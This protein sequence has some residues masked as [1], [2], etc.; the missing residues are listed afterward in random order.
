MLFNI[1]KQRP[2]CLR[3]LTILEG[4]KMFPFMGILL[5]QL[6]CLVF[7]CSL[8]SSRTISCLNSLKIRGNTQL[9]EVK[10]KV[11]PKYHNMMNKTKCCLEGM[12]KGT[13]TTQP[14]GCYVM[15]I[16]KLCLPRNVL[17]PCSQQYTLGL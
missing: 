6:F 3:H 14:R 4:H 8:I 1:A 5:E 16:L 13:H 17:G 11:H 15:Y 9:K 2:N 12:D 10:G 7:L